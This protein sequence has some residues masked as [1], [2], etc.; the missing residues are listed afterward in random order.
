MI[1]AEQ[2]LGTFASDRSHMIKDG[3]W[4]KSPPAY[5]CIATAKSTNNLKEF[6]SMV[7]SE[8]PGQLL[9]YDNFLTFFRNYR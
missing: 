6:I 5:P 7:N 2:F 3:K 9:D 8:V 1:S 4:L